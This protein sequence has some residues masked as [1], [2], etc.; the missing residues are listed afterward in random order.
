MI[1]GSRVFRLKLEY[2]FLAEATILKRNINGD[3]FISMSDETWQKAG[4]EGNVTIRGD[5]VENTPDVF[6]DITEDFN[7]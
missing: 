5:V 6:E 1:I 4:I 3:Y 2:L 7:G